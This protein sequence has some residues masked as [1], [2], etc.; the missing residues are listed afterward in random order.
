MDIR[1]IS[2][3]T[4]ILGESPVWDSSNESLW[5]VDIM[6]GTIHRYLHTTAH[7]QLFKI[8]EV[9]SSLA[10]SRNG[11]MVVSLQ[12]GFAYFYPE[13]GRLYPINSLD[14]EPPSNRLN[15]GKCDPAGRFWS[16]T[17]S[18]VEGGGTL[19]ALEADGTISKKLQQVTC[20]N[21]MAWS[22]DTSQFF[23]I[24]TPSRQVVAYDYSSIDGAIRSKRIVVTIPAEEGFP[25][26]MT[27]DD[28]GMLW[29][30]MWDGGFVARYEPSTG[31][32]LQKIDLPVSRVTSCTFGGDDYTDLYITTA[33]TGLTPAQLEEQP[34]AGHLFVCKQTGHRG[35]SPHKHFSG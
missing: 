19:Y 7:H 2:T 23:F 9:V 10:I 20:P 33:K 30:A 16:G 22:Q 14:G 25:D 17:M 6:N 13:D 27:I 31:K 28:Q 35:M 3:H 26:G 11:H 34:L 8:G 15:D 21:G 32:C 1:H 12:H 4:C 18:P 5:W 24:D 29:I